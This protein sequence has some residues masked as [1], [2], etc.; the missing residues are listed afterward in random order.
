MKAFN[1]FDTDSHNP[2]VEKRE[3]QSTRLYIISLS[4]AFAILVFYT[5]L[6]EETLTYTVQNPSLATYE[7]LQANY[8]NTI[9]C[10]CTRITILYSTFL[11]FNYT[12]HQSCSSQFISS[13]F[14]E[15]LAL[16]KE[17]PLYT[18]DFMQFSV[19]Y[20][21]WLA[22]FCSLSNDNVN[23]YYQQFKNTLFVNAELLNPISF[24]SQA[25]LLVKSLVNHVRSSFTQDITLTRE[26]LGTTQPL[27]ATQNSYSLPIMPSSNE[28]VQISVEPSG[29]SECSCVLNP[30]NCSDEAAFYSYDVVNDSFHLLWSVMGVRVACSPLDSFLQSNLAC[31]YSPVCYETVNDFLVS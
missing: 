5:I 27:S 22:T 8:P 30:T 16:I 19:S 7:K 1:L 11:S 25:Q 2:M 24:N 3:R 6:T 18:S 13:A 28:K 21:E 4:V 9:E 15:Q 17:S 29:F 12:L 23:N 10:S 20:F 26:V 14:I 31:W